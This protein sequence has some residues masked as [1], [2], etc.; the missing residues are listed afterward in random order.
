MRIGIASLVMLLGSTAFA[1]QPAAESS[2]VLYLTDTGIVVMQLSI[3]VDGEGPQARFEHAV[4][5]LLKSLDKNGDGVVTTEEA[6]GKILTVREAQQ[7]QIVGTD[8]LAA[9]VVPD[10]NPKDG[11]IS[12]AELLGYFKRIGLVP[13]AVKFQSRTNNPDPNADGM[14]NQTGEA[15]L[16]EKLDANG[17]K[18]L[19]VEEL[20]NALEVL[21]KLDRDNDET[22]SVAELQPLAAQPRAVQRA[23]MANPVAANNPF[24]SLASGESIPKLIKRIV[25]KYDSADSAKSGVPSLSTKN[26][27]LSRMELGMAESSFAKYDIDGD[28]Q[29]DF[30]ELRPFIA[31]L[32]PTLELTMNLSDG[33]VT[34]TGVESAKIRSL[35][36]GSAHMQLGAAQ[37][38]ASAVPIGQSVDVEAMIKP[39]FMAVDVDA[40]GYLEKSEAPNNALFGATFADMDGDKNDK[41]YLEEIV[42]YLKPR[43]DIARHR[44]DLLMVEQGRRLFDILDSDRDGRLA[45]REVRSVADKLALWDADG[46]GQLSESEIPLQF[47][48]IASAGS[49]PVFSALPQAVVNGAGN[50]AST[51]RTAGPVWFRKM[52]RNSDG[53]ISRREFLGDLDLFDKLDRNHDG[54]IELNEALLAKPE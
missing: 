45:H 42:A 48:M 21:R 16:F 3:L 8:P 41:L 20:G 31:S 30:T 5:A 22:I 47:Q 9:D 36:D 11:K 32:E 12:R 39:F 50:R 4:D 15:P 46:D 24:I 1:G 44:V 26:Q 51:T 17:D 14:A 33:K 35:A 38:T 25:D 52:D 43:F 29:L 7:M 37:F 6:R 49:L 28:G 53:E 10:N 27:K 40:N 34:G 54:A 19:S 13:F 2:K 23:N 18:K